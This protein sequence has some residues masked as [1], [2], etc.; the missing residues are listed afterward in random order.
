MVDPTNRH[1]TPYNCFFLLQSKEN[2]AQ[3]HKMTWQSAAIKIMKKNLNVNLHYPR[4]N[5]LTRLYILQSVSFH[6]YNCNN[7]IEGKCVFTL[8]NIKKIDCLLF[9]NKT[10]LIYADITS[11]SNA[12]PI[13]RLQ[14]LANV[15]KPNRPNIPL[16]M[17]ITTAIA[18]NTAGVRAD[19]NIFLLSLYALKLL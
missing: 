3:L 16:D 6:R 14:K 10:Y 8:L 18:K 9:N 19:L 17:Y 15:Y 13:I 1:P 2:Q 12:M 11:V 7:K 4:E 5:L